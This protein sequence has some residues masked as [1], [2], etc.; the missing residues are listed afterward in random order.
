MDYD[1]LAFWNGTSSLILQILSMF[2][3]DKRSCTKDQEEALIALSSAYHA[4]EAYYERLES[5]EPTPQ[6]EWEIA[7]KWCRVSILLRKYDNGIS[8]RLDLKSRYWREG[9]T[10]SHAVI[11]ESNIGLKLVWAEVNLRLDEEGA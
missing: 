3:R 8:Q 7:E 11:R 10:W 2:P 6:I 4:T 5:N 1:A 9:A